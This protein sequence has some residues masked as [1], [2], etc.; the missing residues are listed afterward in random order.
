M[1][2]QYASKLLNSRLIAHINAKQ[3]LE[4]QVH[5][6]LFCCNGAL[7]RRAMPRLGAVLARDLGE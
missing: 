5:N 2:K 1:V 6:D 7:F 4:V 3:G